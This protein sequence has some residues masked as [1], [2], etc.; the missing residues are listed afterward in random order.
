MEQWLERFNRGVPWPVRAALVV[1]IGAGAFLLLATPANNIGLKLSGRMR[2]CPWARVLS[3]QSDVNWLAGALDRAQAEVK[4]ADHDAALGIDLVRTQERSFWV[5]RGGEQF[6]GRQLIAY[7]LAE[8]RWMI[9]SNPA[10][11]VRPGDVVLDCGAHVGVFTHHALARGAAKV[12][13]VEPEPVNLECLRRNFVAEIAR[14]TVVVVPQGV[15]SAEATLELTVAAGNSGMNS[16]V[17]GAG[18]AKIRIPVTTIDHLRKDLRLGRVD[19]IK[20]DIEGAEREALSGGAET[21]RRF[22]PRLMLDSYHRPDDPV[23]LP[24]LLSGL[25][26]GYRKTC[27]PCE[28]DAAARHYVPHVTYYR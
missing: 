23:V 27:G 20:L 15:W 3:M 2:E 25:Q 1:L 17:L 28:P 10:E 9:R 21:L 6:G 16:T 13:A 12:I 19:F 7:L 26:A 24:A 18:G 22:Q 11:H 4:V 8:H 14:G 5:K